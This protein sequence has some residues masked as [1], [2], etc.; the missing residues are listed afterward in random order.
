M[1]FVILVF[2]VVHISKCV[3]NSVIATSSYESEMAALTSSLPSLAQV[4]RLLG[5]LGIYV[6]KPIP[7]LIDNMAVIQSAMKDTLAVKTRHV[8]LQL[9]KIRD[10][11]EAKQII[12][13]HISSRYNLADVLTK[14][15]FGRAYS[16]AVISCIHRFEYL[17]CLRYFYGC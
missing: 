12:L 16:N 8:N 2:G 1:G 11:I 4:V 9:V 14:P 13:V 6:P 5:N 17:F 7:C 10:L 15:V 3:I